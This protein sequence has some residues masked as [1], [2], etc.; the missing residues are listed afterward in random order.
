MQVAQN[1]LERSEAG[2]ELMREEEEKRI[3]GTKSLRFPN[4]MYCPGFQ[5]VLD[6]D[7]DQSSDSQDDASQRNVL[8]VAKVSSKRRNQP[9][10]TTPVAYIMKSLVEKQGGSAEVL[11]SADNESAYDV[12]GRAHLLKRVKAKVAK[13]RRQAQ[14]RAED[15]FQLTVGHGPDS[16]T[17]A[18]VLKEAFSSFKPGAAS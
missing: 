18:T 5:V 3:V 16:S 13:M 14:E 8:L 6:Y 4:Q 15:A 7:N 2:T 17:F 1:F 12:E 11:E 10:D 9:T